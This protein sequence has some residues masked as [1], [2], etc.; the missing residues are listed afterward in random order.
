MRKLSKEATDTIRAE[1]LE[2]L[3]TILKQAELCVLC[4]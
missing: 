2:L 3:E 4:I 1:W